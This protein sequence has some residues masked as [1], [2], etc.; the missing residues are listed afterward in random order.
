MK[1]IPWFFEFNK[2]FSVQALETMQGLIPDIFLRETGHRLTIRL[3][4]D[5]KKMLV[6]DV[7]PDCVPQ[8]RCLLKGYLVREINP[9]GGFYF[10]SGPVESHS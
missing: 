6:D 5:G 7:P 1:T 9:D 3:S 10:R 4:D 8:M 2:T